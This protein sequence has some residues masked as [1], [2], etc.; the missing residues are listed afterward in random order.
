MD[1]AER[2]VLRA[3]FGLIVVL[4]I[5]CTNMM[6]EAFNEAIR[7]DESQA[8]VDPLSGAYE[9]RGFIANEEELI[10]SSGGAAFVPHLVLNVVKVSKVAAGASGIYIRAMGEQ[11]FLELRWSQIKNS[12]R[13]VYGINEPLK[14]F[15]N[16]KVSINGSIY[17]QCGNGWYLCEEGDETHCGSIFNPVDPTHIELRNFTADDLR[18]G[19]S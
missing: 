3:A 9:V 4:S 16:K 10:E 11:E 14:S 19:K 13:G 1:I 7:Q 12:L 2:F 6:D 8:K 17:N 5:S 18:I 15:L